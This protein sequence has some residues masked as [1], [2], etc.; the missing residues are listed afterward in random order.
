MALGYIK[1]NIN[2][3][4]MGYEHLNGLEVERI[5][6]FHHA[7]GKGLGKQLMQFAISIAKQQKKE[8]VFL[9]AMDS[10]KDALNFYKSIGFSEC[11]RFQ[12]PMPTFHLMKAECRGMIILKKDIN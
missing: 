5:Y 2:A 11:G 1:I 4:M 8:Y 6:L 9:K 7:T 10:S 3:A 12:L